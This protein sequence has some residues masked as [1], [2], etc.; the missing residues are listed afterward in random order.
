LNAPVLYF[1]QRPWRTPNGIAI[2]AS[3]EPNTRPGGMLAPILGNPQLI[4]HAAKQFLEVWRIT[5]LFL[6]T[7]Y[8]AN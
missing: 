4:E 1:G 8:F 7:V 2:R 5:P 6:I 3:S